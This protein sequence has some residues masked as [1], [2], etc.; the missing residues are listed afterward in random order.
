MKQSYA[1]L[2]AVSHSDHSRSAVRQHYARIAAGSRSFHEA[3]SS[4]LSASSTTSGNLVPV[5]VYQNNMSEL[6]YLLRLLKTH[7][8][9]Q[10]WITLIAPPSNFCLSLFQQAGIQASQIRIARPTATYDA[11]AL[12]QKAMASDTSS[13]VIAFGDFHDFEHASMRSEDQRD[14]AKSMF[15]QGFV[16]NG[17]P[18]HLH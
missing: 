18:E 17:L 11:A 15:A 1:T 4:T 7:S 10:K 16:I 14:S 5:S 3:D 12:M 9:S 13:A 8:S 2:H 6:A